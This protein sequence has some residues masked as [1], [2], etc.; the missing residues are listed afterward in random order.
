MESILWWSIW[1]TDIFAKKSLFF[2]FHTHS[3]SLLNLSVPLTSIP[4]AGSRKEK[5]RNGLIKDFFRWRKKVLL[6]IIYTK[7]VCLC[8]YDTVLLNEPKSQIKSYKT[9]EKQTSTAANF[10]FIFSQKCPF[11]FEKYVYTNTN[12]AQG[13]AANVRKHFSAW[14]MKPFEFQRTVKM[15]KCK[16]FRLRSDYK[17]NSA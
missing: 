16:S 12:G 5:A 10:S 17:L 15:S 11:T 2:F 3:S 9:G 4:N 1:L 7:C 14:H 8:K 6:N 13:F